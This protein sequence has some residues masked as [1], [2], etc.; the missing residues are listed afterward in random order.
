MELMRSFYLSL[1]KTVVSKRWIWRRR[2]SLRA[3]KTR[4]LRS[5]F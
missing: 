1:R 2:I 5:W 3:P 4:R